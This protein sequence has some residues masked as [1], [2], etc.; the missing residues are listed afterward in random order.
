MKPLQKAHK[1]K[2]NAE[3][4]RRLCYYKGVYNFTEVESSMKRI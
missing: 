3:R 1:T 2:A 4:I